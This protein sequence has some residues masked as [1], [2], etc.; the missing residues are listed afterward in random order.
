SLRSGNEQQRHGTS[1]GHRSITG[2]ST[3]AV[4]DPVLQP[5][6]APGRGN[7]GLPALSRVATMAHAVS[8][9][10]AQAAAEGGL[11]RFM[12]RSM[13]SR[14]AGRGA[15]GRRNPPLMPLTLLAPPGPEFA[16]LAQA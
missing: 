12:Q 10:L 6:A 8:G 11:T 13:T 16:I 7:H 2:A 1:G 9:P 14:P 3:G 5:R 4:A 15:A